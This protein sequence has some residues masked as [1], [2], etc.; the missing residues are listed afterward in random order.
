[1]VDIEYRVFTY[2]YICI[3][4]KTLKSFV[5]LSLALKEIYNLSRK[6]F[7]NGLISGENAC[8]DKYL[9]S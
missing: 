4:V 2:I 3:N 9:S 6:H 8:A 1:M 5:E 7:E